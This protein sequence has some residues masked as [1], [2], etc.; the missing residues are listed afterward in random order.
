MEFIAVVAIVLLA[1]V[2]SYSY[3]IFWIYKDS[4]KYGEDPLAW[5]FLASFLFIGVLPFYLNSRTNNKV[6]CSRCEKW[7]PK[8]LK[9]CPHCGGKNDQR[10]K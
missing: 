3:F 7:F 10:A 5:T 2:I 1:I 9:E 8:L 6:S 4:Q